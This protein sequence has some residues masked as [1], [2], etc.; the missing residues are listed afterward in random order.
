MSET[1]TLLV[2][3]GNYKAFKIL[4]AAELN[5]V[6]VDVPPFFIGTDD[7]TD[8]FKSKSPMG[9]VPILETANGSIFESNAIARFIAGLN[10]A[11][12]LN[13]NGYF[14]EAQVAQWM[15]FCSKEIDFPACVWMYPAFGYVPANAAAT[16]KA[17]ADLAAALTVVE[18]ALEGKQFLVGSAMSLADITI[19]SSLVYPFKF[20]CDAKYRGKFPKVCSWFESCVSQKAFSDIVGKVTLCAD[21]LE[22]GAAQVAIPKPKQEK[23]PKDQKPK[24][25]KKAKEP[26]EDDDMPPPAPKKPDHPFKIMDKENKS[27]FVM[28]AWKVQYSNEKGDYTDSMNYFWDNYDSQGWSLWRGE[29]MW[30]EECERLFMTSNLI[31][32]FI[33]R[34]EEIRKWFF[35]TMTIRGVEG[36]G[37]MKVTGHFLIRGQDIKPLIDCNDDAEQYKWSKF[38]DIDEKTKKEFYDFWCSE[39]PLDGEACLD[40]RVYK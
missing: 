17:R 3:G 39:G 23:K 5:G 31:G 35:G 11:T 33:Q 34:T 40:S 21:E 7:Q 2:D 12:A 13:G 24:Q 14:D 20:V 1:Y 10:P 29:Y 6:K 16:A 38:D 8:N 26:K 30:N 37:T 32:G 25:E 18:S 4:I 15:D 19:V 9:R 28:D 36:K 27:P 22:V